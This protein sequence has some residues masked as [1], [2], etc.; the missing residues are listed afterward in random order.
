LRTLIQAQPLQ[1]L[2]FF[3]GHRRTGIKFIEQIHIRPQLSNHS[4]IH[5]LTNLSLLLQVDVSH[6]TYH[7]VWFPA[8]ALFTVVQ[9]RPK[10]E[11]ITA[12]GRRHPRNQRSQNY[13][14]LTLAQPH[15]QGVLLVS[16]KPATLTGFDCPTS[17]AGVLG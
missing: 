10:E 7:N 14:L 9:A 16:N 8:Q 13:L 1:W 5:A 11:R 4:Y 15:S 17:Q 6:V 3:T 12:M 2:T